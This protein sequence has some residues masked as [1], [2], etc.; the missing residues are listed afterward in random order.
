MTEP[1]EIRAGDKVTLRGSDPPKVGRV[2]GVLNL[3]AGFLAGYLPVGTAENLLDVLAWTWWKG[4]PHPVNE[5]VAD[6]I[7]LTEE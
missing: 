3:H 1:S 5:R 6:L 4:E 2:I 7:K